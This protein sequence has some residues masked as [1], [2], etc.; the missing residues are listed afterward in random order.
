MSLYFS[1]DDSN[2]ISFNKKECSVIIDYIPKNFLL[3]N[4]AYKEIDAGRAGQGRIN[5]STGDLKFTHSDASIKSGALSMGISHVFDSYLDSFHS[6]SGQQLNKGIG[7]NW[8]LNIQQYLLRESIADFADENNSKVFTYLDGN[9]NKHIFKE[10]YYYLDDSKVKHYLDI[11]EVHIDE[12]EKLYY[13]DDKKYKVEKEVVTSAGMTLISQLEGFKGIKYI[14]T[15]IDE[16]TQVKD[17]IK[18]LNRNIGDLNY[19]ISIDKQKICLLALNKKALDI[20]NEI[21]K[22]SAKDSEDRAQLERDLYSAQKTLKKLELLRVPFI[23]PIDELEDEDEVN[24]KVLDDV[25]KEVETII[26]NPL[27]RVTNISD[28]GNDPDAEDIPTIHINAS[29]KL[30]PKTLKYYAVNKYIDDEQQKATWGDL[31]NVDVYNPKKDSLKDYQKQLS[32]WSNTLS[33]KHGQYGLRNIIGEVLGCSNEDERNDLFQELDLFFGTNTLHQYMSLNDVSISQYDLDINQVIRDYKSCEK[34][35]GEYQDEL[36]KLENQLKKLERQVPVHYLSDENGTTFGFARFDIGDETIKNNSVEAEN[37][38]SDQKNIVLPNKTDFFLNQE[39]VKNNES[40][41]Y[42]LV[43][44]A[45]KWE[46]VIYFEFNDE[47]QIEKIVGDNSTVGLKYDSNTGMLV[48]L[49]DNRGRETKYHYMKNNLDRITYNDGTK[50]T[51]SYTGNLMWTAYAPNGYRVVFNYPESNRMLIKEGMRTIELA[52]NSVTKLGVCDK[53]TTELEFSNGKATTVTEDSGKQFVYIF[54]ND[55]RPITVYEKKDKWDSC[56]AKT[57]DYS[58]GRVVYSSSPILYGEDYLKD[59]CYTSEDGNTLC[60]HE[61]V[62][63][64]YLGDVDGIGYDVCGGDIYSDEGLYLYSFNDENHGINQSNDGVSYIVT[65]DSSREVVGKNVDIEKI[66]NSGKKDFVL[67]AW[68]QADS[69]YAT[70]RCTC[71]SDRVS[72]DEVYDELEKEFLQYADDVQKGRRFELGATITYRNTKTDELVEENVY[73]S[74]DWQQQGVQYC[75]LPISLSENSAYELN[76]IYA[77]VDY[78]LNTNSATIFDMQ[79]K[80]GDWEYSEYNSDGAKTYEE[81]SKSKYITEYVYDDDKK[82]VKIIVKDEHDKDGK[83]FVT[84]YDYN[85][86]NALIRTVDYNGI[87]NE[88]EYND[89]GII[90]RRIKYHQDEPSSKYYEESVLDDKGFETGAVNEFGEKVCDYTNIPNTD[91]VSV[92][93]DKNGEQIAYGYDYNDDTLRSVSASVDG[94]QNANVMGYTVGTLTKLSHNGTD[95]NYTYENYGDVT[96]VEIAGKQ[97]MKSEFSKDVEGKRQNTSKSY[98]KSDKDYYNYNSIADLEGQVSEVQ[99]SIFE[100]EVASPAETILRYEY[101]KLDRLILSEDITNN[102]KQ[103][104]DYDN[105]GNACAREY[106]NENGRIFAVKN[107]YDK[108]GNVLESELHFGSNVRSTAYT[109]EDTPD[110]RLAGITLPNGVVQTP[111]YDKLG[112]LSGIEQQKGNNSFGKDIY[113][114]QVGDHTSNLVASEWFENNGVRKERLA[115]SYDEKGNIIAIK[116]NNVEIV[117]YTYDS[118]SRLVRED[119]KKLD[120]TTTFAYDNGG[121]ITSRTEYKYSL[122]DT[123]NLENVNTYNYEYAAKGWRD[124]MLAYNGAVCG[125]YDNLGNP[126]IYRGKTLSWSHGRQLDS[127]GDVSYQYNANGVRVAKT[128]N[129]V[130]TKFYID[131]TVIVA[132]EVGSNLIVFT[133]GIDGLNGF[134]LNGTEYFYKKNIQ[135]DI[136]AIMDSSGNEIVRYVYDAWGNHE[137]YVL[138]S[139]EYNKLYEVQNS[140]YAEIAQLNPYRYRGYYYDIETGLYYLNTRYYDSEVGRFINADDISNVEPDGINGLN[141]YAYCLDNP[142]MLIDD[143]GNKPKWWQWLIGALIVVAVTAA[144]V[145][146][147]GA[148]AV[149]IGAS[150]AVTLGVMAGAAIGGLVVGGASLIKQGT[151]GGEMDYGQ[152][153]LNTFIGGAVGALVG[154]GAGYLF[155]SGAAAAIGGG[156]SFAVAG[157]SSLAIAGGGSVSVG[158]AVSGTGVLEGLAA[159]GGLILFASTERPGDNRKQNEQFRAAMRELGITSKS[160]PRWRRAH[161]ALRKVA[162]MGYKLLVA[163]IRALLG[164]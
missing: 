22:I 61:T 86:L 85:A 30:E 141:L 89:K 56:F 128:A 60:D 28:C 57:F 148:A 69:A 117:R 162:P 103:I 84:T 62:Y 73:A 71:F 123:S 87:V 54:D 118:L 58:N 147:A 7:R 150:A 51:F 78:S 25:Y 45:D 97:Y 98:F 5:L 27:I 1:K 116:E 26:D 82:L 20:Q 93:T 14:Q 31:E 106:Q 37:N 114:K 81:S 129:G 122:A 12:N 44:I 90:I 70:R 112:R 164:L 72:N 134:M 113:Y 132:Q 11:S 139:G 67:T 159:L 79:L 38:L 124:Q 126:G 42:R 104:I 24:L 46:N 32:D 36:I 108:Q 115:Y 140:A 43:M 151:S 125:E 19:N 94:Q 156:S 6:I 48:S 152:L 47:N 144:V 92:S 50:S 99:Y 131:G 163:F 127:I 53:S 146:T 74:F 119:N 41:I 66:K 102:T 17:S 145:L 161:D 111:V 101:D 133:R 40:E 55:G 33:S 13:Y 95:I 96:K 10:K 137:T 121:N 143:N 160:D 153:A 120:K 15:E 68:A 105:Q 77:Y 155:G 4:N 158:V 75:A 154:G 142:V 135:G 21:Q 59:S 100:N 9:G 34:L 130:T 49:I 16:M 136:I 3:E 80:E 88:N 35:K 23:V 65:L 39:P 29:G 76:S 52:H 2:R 109:Y 18:Q 157:G 149:A 64:N 107:N 91:I 63:A 138:V 110:R 8:K 83:E